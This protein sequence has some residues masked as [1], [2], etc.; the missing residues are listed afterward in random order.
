MLKIDSLTD[1]GLVRTKNED[2]MEIRQNK[3]GH[4]LVLVADGM[5]GHNA[6]N[7]ASKMAAKIIAENFSKIDKPIDYKVFVEKVTKLANHEIY[8]AAMLKPSYSKM[9]TTLSFLI[10]DNKKMY[11]G[12]VG[13]SRIYFINKNSIQQITKD[14][15]VIQEM[16]DSKSIGEEEAQNSPLK[17]VLLQALGTSKKLSLEIKEIKP[18]NKFKILLCSDGLTANVSDEEIKNIVNC[19]ISIEE[20]LKDLVELAKIKDGSDNISVLLMEEV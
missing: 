17:N 12:H 3:L 10:Y 16:L 8:K 13:D 9:G 4:H 19:D 7:V 14:H 11:T 1:V 6:G 5:G 15:T 18:P 2:S 20:K